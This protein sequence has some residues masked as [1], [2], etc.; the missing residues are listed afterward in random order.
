MTHITR[1]EVVRYN[2]STLAE[3]PVHTQKVL[4]VYWLD[5]LMHPTGKDFIADQ[6][7]L[8]PNKVMTMAG[9]HIQEAMNMAAYG[10]HAHIVRLC[11][12][13]DRVNLDEVMVWAAEGGCE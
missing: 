13:Y 3:F 4:G 9:T 10:G 2:G 8:S 11:R 5:V 1:H 6:H 7:I 12:D